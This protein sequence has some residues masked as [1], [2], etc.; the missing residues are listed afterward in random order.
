MIA[1]WGAIGAI[2][3]ADGRLLGAEAGLVLALLVLFLSWVIIS[4]NRT[5]HLATLIRAMR[6]PTRSRIERS[7]GER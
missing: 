3:L 2:G 5:R 7:P 4:E 1:R 6:G